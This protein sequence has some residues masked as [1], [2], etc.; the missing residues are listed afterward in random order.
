MK[1]LKLNSS[2]ERKG[3][4]GFDLDAGAVFEGGDGA[5]LGE[6]LQL[7]LSLHGG[8]AGDPAGGRLAAR[9]VALLRLGG[10]GHAD[11]LPH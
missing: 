3:C 6:A 4:C 10:R 1:R 11:A 2:K 7:A 9:V 5:L 8:H